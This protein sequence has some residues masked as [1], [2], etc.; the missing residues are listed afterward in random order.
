M[1]TVVVD[2][3]AVVNIVPEIDT[4]IDNIGNVFGNNGKV[5]NLQGVELGNSKLTKG[6]Y[7]VNGKKVAVTK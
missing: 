6:I 2:N 5:Y 4:G 3:E 1:I 7:I